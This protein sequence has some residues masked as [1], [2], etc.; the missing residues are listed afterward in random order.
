M[1]EL[2]GIDPALK[3]ET[4]KARGTEIVSE[5]SLS[6]PLGKVRTRL[7]I[8]EDFSGWEMTRAVGYF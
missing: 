1:A 6:Y 3:H 2:E 8:S 7:E 4:S 5:D